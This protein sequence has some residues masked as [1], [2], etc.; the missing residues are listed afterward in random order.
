MRKR[1][2]TA[3][4]LVTTT[5]FSAG[6]LVA[7]A[8]AGILED[9]L[10]SKLVAS[11]VPPELV[12]AARSIGSGKAMGIDALAGVFNPIDDTD[13]IDEKQW[14]EL[15]AISLEA[16]NSEL[17]KGT[18]VSLGTVNGIMQNAALGG[19]DAVNNNKIRQQTKKIAEERQGMVDLITANSQDTESTLD[20]MN[21]KLKLDGAAVSNQLTEIDLRTKALTQSQISNANDLRQQQDKMLEERNREIGLA[22]DRLHVKTITS[23]IANPSYDYT[24]TTVSSN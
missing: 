9:L 6:A 16:S 19:V 21:Q 14:E 20:A 7:S 23:A 17:L 8:Q 24:T 10:G 1:T 3:I 4:G 12:N 18:G 11:I 22:A 5:L 2:K 13:N 15:G